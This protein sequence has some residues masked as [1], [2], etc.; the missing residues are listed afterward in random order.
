MKKTAFVLVVLVAAICATA[1]W[2][3]GG[4]KPGGPPPPMVICP[5]MLLLPPPAMAIDNIT[6]GCQL[7]TDQAAALKTILTS[8]EA[9]IQPKLQALAEK[10]KALRTAVLVPTAQYDQ[11]AVDTATAD[12]QTAEAAV[13]TGSIY[14]WNQISASGILSA[15]Q[16]A[17]LM[18]GP[19]PGGPPPGPPPS[20]GSSSG[21][22]SSSTGT[23]RR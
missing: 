21:G 7:T 12:A 17:K 5:A 22:S 11:A 15:D 1:A 10:T 9:D 19:G 8:S 6:K 13:V 14:W 16:L 23:R 3:Q 18:A 4:P 20:S 2:S